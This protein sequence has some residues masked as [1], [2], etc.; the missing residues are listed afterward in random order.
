MFFSIIIPTYNRVFILKETLLSVISQSFADFEI[1]VVDDGSTDDTRE[2]VA[3]LNE[4]NLHYYYKENEERSI[5]RNFGA[6]H[7]TGKYLIF[8]DSDDK[9]KPGYLLS[10]YAFLLGKQFEPKFIF[11]GYVILNPDQKPLYEY[12]MEGFF[13]PSKL[14]YGNFLGCSS[15]VVDTTLFKKYYFSA[16]KGLILFEDWELWLRIIAENKLYCY[17]AKSIV[18]IN[19]GNRSVLNYDPTEIRARILL[20]KNHVLKTSLAVRTSFFHRRTFLMGTYSYSALHIAMTKKNRALAVKHLALSF[21]SCPLIIF[22]RR[23]F[24]IIKHLF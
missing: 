24:G 18:M 7:A 16:E 8:L 9:M 23:F 11:T 4:N 20:F 15:V 5:A 10:V 3:G 2:M 12:G 1:I 17:P 13:N 19:H 6:D 21:I 22:K 14:F